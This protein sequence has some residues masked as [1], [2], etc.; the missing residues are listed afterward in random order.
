MNELIQSESKAIFYDEQYTLLFSVNFINLEECIKA[1]YKCSSILSKI[2]QRSMAKYCVFK[3]DNQVLTIVTIGDK[4]IEFNSTTVINN[5][6][7]KNILQSIY[8]VHSLQVALN[9]NKDAFIAY[10]DHHNYNTPKF[11]KRDYISTQNIVKIIKL[12]FKNGF[13][14]NAINCDNKIADVFILNNRFKLDTFF[15]HFK[16]EKAPR[17]FKFGELKSTIILLQNYVNAVDE[18]NQKIIK[19]KDQA[20]FGTYTDKYLELFI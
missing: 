12:E 7:V 9:F 5:L 16:N 20:S 17:E 15:I 3:V 2:Y 11:N 6:N 18:F 19:T 10:I 1:I 14:I 13:Q 4:I 8:D